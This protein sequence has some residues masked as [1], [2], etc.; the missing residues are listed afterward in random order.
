MTITTQDNYYI[1][2]VPSN[3][4]KYRLPAGYEAV[5]NTYVIIETSNGIEFGKIILSGIPEDGKE[6]KITY[7]TVKHI[8]RKAEKEDFQEIQALPKQTH[9]HVEKANKLC[10]EWNI[11]I[12]IKSCQMTFDKK[13]AIMYYQKLK[14][15]KRI[16]STRLYELG[17]ELGKKLAANVELKEVSSRDCAKILGGLASC[18]QVV[19]CALFLKET[20][21]VGVRLAK[22]QGINMNPKNL[23][24]LCGKLKC[25]LRY[26]Q[27]NYNNGE[28]DISL[29]HHPELAE[30]EE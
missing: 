13:R 24:G 3:R 28:L 23:C 19:C 9:S 14:D 29:V 15:R 20:K 26:E 7:P 12:I 25:C 16:K 5:L 8:I 4:S 27:A 10:N 18:G 1:V 21:S 6:Q 17:I 30:D 11:G 2:Y 22:N